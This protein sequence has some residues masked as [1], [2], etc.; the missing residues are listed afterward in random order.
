MNKPMRFVRPDYGRDYQKELQSDSRPVPEFLKLNAPDTSGP[1]EVPIYKYLSRDYHE[2]EI[3]KVWK[4]SWQWAC[5]EEQIPEVG[6]T[7]VYDVGPL[8]V[9]VVRVAPDRIKAYPNACLHRGRRLCDY[10]ARVTELRCPFHGFAWNL[11][12]SFRSMPSPWDLPHVE[13]DKFGLPECKVETWGGF[14]FINMDPAAAPLADTL[15]VVPEHFARWD[16]ENRAIIANVS[17]VMRCNW[18]INQEGFLESWHVAATHPQFLASFGAITGQYDVFGPVNRTLSAIM[19]ESTPILGRRPS[20]QEKYDSLTIQYLAGQPGPQLPDGVKARSYSAEN[21][22]K[23]L[24]TVVGPRA[25]NFCDAEL[26]DSIWYSVFPNFTP[27]GGPGVRQQYR[28][29][30]W[31]DDPEMS[32]MDIVILAPFKGERPPPAPPRLL[33][34]DQSWREAPELGSISL[35]EDQDAYNLEAVQKGLHMTAR[36]SIVLAKYQESRIRHFHRLLDEAMA[37]P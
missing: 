36:K 33:G 31:G 18:K 27:W 4:R 20:E 13:H 7:F 15:G 29:R 9:V 34:P 3:E 10:D 28:W 12:G 22:R 32:V 23:Y 30:P 1:D 19:G 35:V 26:V 6:D 24:E 14:V 16:L 5:R 37:R 11:D 8:S 25:E 2:Q 21:G 17:K